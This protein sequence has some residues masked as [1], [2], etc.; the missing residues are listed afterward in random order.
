MEEI[1][2]QSNNKN[3]KRGNPAWGKKADGTGK[4]G[5][6]GGKPPNEL[7][8]T[9]LQREML[10]QPCPYAEGKTWAEWLARRGMELAGENAAYYREL[11]DRLE[12]KVTQPIEATTDTVV[13]FIIGKG[14]DDSQGD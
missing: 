11:M 6:L 1:E 10:N 2:K 12:G 8:I 5:N 4:S 9:H 13:R 14:Y 3:L 7:C